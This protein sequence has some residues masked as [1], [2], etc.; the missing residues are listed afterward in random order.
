MDTI[1]GKKNEELGH[2]LLDSS[3]KENINGESKEDEGGFNSLMENPIE[4]EQLYEENAR[5]PTENVVIDQAGTA[6]PPQEEPNS[7]LE[8]KKEDEEMGDA[9][10]TENAAACEKNS[11]VKVE[12]E[13][14]GESAEMKDEENG[15]EIVQFEED[16]ETP[17]NQ[18]TPGGG[19]PINAEGSNHSFLLDPQ[20]GEGY[21]SGT[22]DEQAA[23]MQEL[24]NFF[25]EKG[26]E[27]KPPKF[28]GIGLNCLK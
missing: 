8:C 25:R 17:L 22:E 26:L 4:S 21:E 20:L 27:F 18:E 10:Q 6:E 11:A 19:R 24:A 1:E 9:N 2:D 16:C 15:R 12:K 23:F 14:G 28:Y 3:A 5:L 13:N 7:A